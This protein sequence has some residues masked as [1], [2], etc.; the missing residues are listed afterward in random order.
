M[1]LRSLASLLET[2]KIEPLLAERRESLWIAHDVLAVL[3]TWL[4]TGSLD[5]ARDDKSKSE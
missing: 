3:P 4:D 2:A 1:L 5:C